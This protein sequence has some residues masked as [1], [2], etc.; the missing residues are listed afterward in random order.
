[1]LNKLNKKSRTKENYLKFR[2]AYKARSTTVHGGSDE[3]LDGEL[4]KAGFNNIN[5]LNDYLE[6]QF[7]LVVFW[8]AKMKMRDRPYK[9]RYGWESLLWDM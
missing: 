5:E 2:C 9:A 7:R 6:E 1:M 3:K 4:K 8:L